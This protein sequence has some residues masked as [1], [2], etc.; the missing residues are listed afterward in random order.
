MLVLYV[1]NRALEADPE[2][3]NQLDPDGYNGLSSS[4]IPRGCRLTTRLPRVQVT[5]YRTARCKAGRRVFLPFHHSMHLPHRALGQVTPVQRVHIW[6]APDFRHCQRGFSLS[7]PCV[8]LAPA[9]LAPRP[10]TQSSR[11]RVPLRSCYPR[12]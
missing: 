10:C 4:F 7:Y 3:G 1:R 11:A 2:A 9:P 8:L 12:W 6:P 5:A